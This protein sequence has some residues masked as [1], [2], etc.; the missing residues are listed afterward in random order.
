MLLDSAMEAIASTISAEH[1]QES[2]IL[3]R[4]YTGSN[5]ASDARKILMRRQIL[6]FASPNASAKGLA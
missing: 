4:G 5:S 1:V 2:R 3:A 6:A